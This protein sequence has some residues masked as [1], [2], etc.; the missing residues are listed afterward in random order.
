MTWR[1]VQ[2]LSVESAIQVNPADPDWVVNGAGRPYSHKYGYGTFDTYALLERTKTFKNVGPQAKI[3]LK[4]SPT[5]DLAIPGQ[6]TDGVTTS[7]IVS[8]E[9]LKG[10][11]R[12]EHVEVTV[13]IA[14][15]KRGELG[16]NL[17]S[18]SGFV[19]KVMEPRRWDDSPDF[20]DWTMMS[21]AHWYYFLLCV[22]HLF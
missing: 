7:L 8:K 12:L 22:D 4:S 10:L 15:P 3:S 11:K 14:H 17:I 6:S 1:D 2:R 20:N 13:R 9:S 18:P 19:S 5:L 16:L 21:V